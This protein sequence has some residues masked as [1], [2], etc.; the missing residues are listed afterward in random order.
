MA[1]VSLQLSVVVCLPLASGA[2]SAFSRSLQLLLTREALC[3]LGIGDDGGNGS[4]QCWFLV[5]VVVW[6]SSG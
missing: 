2:R 4:K 1:A 3:R 6:F 5:V